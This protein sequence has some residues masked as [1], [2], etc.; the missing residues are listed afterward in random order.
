MDVSKP[1]SSVIPSLDG[2]VLGAL[3]GTTMPLN[4]TEVH[5]LAGEGSLS[6]VRRVLVRLVG[7]G[8]VNEVPGGYVLNRDHVAAPVA[9]ALTRLWGECI[10]RI[11]SAIRAWP[12]SPRLVGV[13][14]SAARRDGDEDSDIDLLVVCDHVGVAERGA[15][16]ADAVQ[17]WTGN[18][19]H[20]VMLTSADLRRI[21]RA[22]ERV[23]EEWDRD[24]V[25]IEGSHDVL[26]AEG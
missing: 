3:A 22:R 7:T 4:L 2:P 17:R 9:E 15:D 12:E 20:V 26:W 13:Y 1:I 19:V 18:P 25:V 24:L 16:L 6:G 10:D 8:L 5:R 23:L 11:R 14:G 21:R